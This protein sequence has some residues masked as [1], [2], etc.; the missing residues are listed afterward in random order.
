MTC[1][2]FSKQ[3]FHSHVYRNAEKDASHSVHLHVHTWYHQAFDQ[4][5]FV[6]L[7]ETLMRQDIPGRFP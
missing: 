5:D 7:F 2:S 1:Y 4:V 6:T 3:T